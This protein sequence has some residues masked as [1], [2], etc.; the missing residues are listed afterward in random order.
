MKDSYDTDVAAIRD[1]YIE[2]PHT[3]DFAILVVAILLFRR[4][5]IDART[6]LLFLA[7]SVLACTPAL[8]FRRDD[9]LFFPVSFAALFYGMAEYEY[10][11]GP[12]RTEISISPTRSTLPG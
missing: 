11:S 7:A 1:K 10:L 4:R 3:T 12:G 6:P 5:R 9:M 2:S 8:T